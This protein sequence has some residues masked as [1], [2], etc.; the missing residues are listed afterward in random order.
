MIRKWL[1]RQALRFYE[2]VEGRFGL[3][4]IQRAFVAYLY[5]CL[6]ASLA[7]NVLLPLARATNAFVLQALGYSP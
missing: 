7:C 3:V 2:F 5:A 6:F 1:D 4:A